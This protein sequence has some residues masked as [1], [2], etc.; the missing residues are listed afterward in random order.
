MGECSQSPA[1]YLSPLFYSRNKNEMCI[2]SIKSGQGGDGKKK[3][4]KKDRH[5]QMLEGFNYC[6]Y[7]ATGQQ[8]AFGSGLDRISPVQLSLNEAGAWLWAGLWSDMRRWDCMGAGGRNEELLQIKQA[9]RGLRPGWEKNSPLPCAFSPLP[10]LSPTSHVLFT[11]GKIRRCWLNYLACVLGFPFPRNECGAPRTLPK[12][13]TWAGSI[14]VHE[15][16]TTTM[17]HT[18]LNLR[19]KIVDTAAAFGQNGPNLSIYIFLIVHFKKSIN[20]NP[21]K[22]S[23]LCVVSSASG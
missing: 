11:S 23:Q 15:N 21:W 5:L 22:H 9:P 10:L 8:G 1:V 13:L 20:P 16:T 14:K 4:K 6:L 19:N 12:L 7:G 18:Q 2:L 17:Q 3:K